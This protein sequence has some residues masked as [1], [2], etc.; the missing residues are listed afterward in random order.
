MKGTCHESRTVMPLL[1]MAASAMAQAV[2][3]RAQAVNWYEW[4]ASS[5]PSSRE[6][7]AMAYDLSTHSTLLF[8]GCCSG[9][10]TTRGRGMAS[11]EGPSNSRRL[12]RLHAQRP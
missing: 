3:M 10:G 7:M 1:L 6:D 2:T 8:A 12:A 9:L 11:L 5:G 4:P